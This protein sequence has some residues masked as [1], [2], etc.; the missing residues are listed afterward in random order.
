[1]YFLI[2]D[3]DDRRL[4]ELLGNDL[5]SERAKS[6]IGNEVPYSRDNHLRKP[7]CDKSL[8]SLSFS[9][10]KDVPDKSSFY[11]YSTDGYLKKV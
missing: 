6:P 2:V 1:M 10:V 8:P 7:K 3:F 4:N 5:R 9:K 11:V